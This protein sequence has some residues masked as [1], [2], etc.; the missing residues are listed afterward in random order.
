MSSSTGHQSETF[1]NLVSDSCLARDQADKT[2]KDMSARLLAVT[3]AP[4]VKINE[5]MKDLYIPVLNFKKPK[6]GRIDPEPE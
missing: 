6:T 1:R 4:Y 3:L 2:R 5:Q